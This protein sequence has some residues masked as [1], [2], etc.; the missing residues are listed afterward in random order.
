MTYKK[1]DEELILLE[2]KMLSVKTY[3]EDNISLIDSVMNTIQAEQDNAYNKGSLA[4]LIKLR[5]TFEIQLQNETNQ[6][7]KTAI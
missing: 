5:W 2:K 7:A 3:Y 1:A 6:C 4:L